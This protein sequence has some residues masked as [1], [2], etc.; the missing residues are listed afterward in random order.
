MPDTTA[1]ERRQLLVIFDSHGIIYR[2]YFALR[3]VLQV[4]KT[5]EMTAA[6]FGYANSLLHVLQ[7]LQ[8]SYVIAAWDG[9]ERTF[10]HEADETYKA[11]R[12]P[13]PDDLRPQIGRV[14]EMLDAFRIPVIEA[15][16]YEA[17]DVVGTIAAQGVQA[18]LDVVVVTQIGRAHV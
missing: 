9:P 11:T 10:R 6:V 2:S 1:P 5:G 8:P 4:R 17:D 18:G 14:R 16:G 12:L 15:P 7:E 3:D 13:M